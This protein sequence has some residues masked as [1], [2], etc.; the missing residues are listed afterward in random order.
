MIARDRDRLQVLE[1]HYRTDAAAARH[2]FVRNDGSIT[3]K[4]F[5]RGTDDDL[6]V[7]YRLAAADLL[8]FFVQGG[9]DLS[10][11]H[12]PEIRCVVEC[13][14]VVFDLDPDGSIG[15]PA[16][17]ERVIPRFFQV[18]SEIAPAV[19][20]SQETRLGRPRRHVEPGCARAPGSRKR[21]CADDDDI[22][23]RKWL[24][25][26]AD[27][28]ADD[29]RGHD[30]AAEKQAPFLV[31]PRIFRYGSASQ[32]DLHDRAH[33]TFVFCRHRRCTSLIC[34]WNRS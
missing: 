27:G 29:L 28:I 24:R 10:R 23:F 5:S 15:F 31:R 9:L 7:F 19:G 12:A 8:E 4:V 17:H 34:Y 21:S 20:G 14:P 11:L 3:D 22:A 2:P 30:L 25:V 32:I 26:R 16:D 1:P 18:V 33:V 6:A 13:E